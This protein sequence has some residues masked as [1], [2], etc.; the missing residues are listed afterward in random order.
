VK[1]RNQKLFCHPSDVFNSNLRRL[2]ISDIRGSLGGYGH[3][4]HHAVWYMMTIIFLVRFWVAGRSSDS[5]DVLAKSQD[6]M[7]THCIRRTVLKRWSSLLAS[8]NKCYGKY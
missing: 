6:V 4:R 7:S 1:S 8:W 5:D 2:T 3:R